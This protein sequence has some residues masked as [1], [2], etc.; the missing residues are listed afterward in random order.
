MAFNV[1]TFK[2]SNFGSDKGGTSKQSH[3]EL[4]VLPPSGILLSDKAFAGIN[5]FRFRT[6]SAEIPGRSIT[7]SEYK[8]AG[9]GLTQKMGYGVV[10]P[11]V[12]VTMVC[13]RDLA[14]KRLFTAWQS[15]IIGNHS[16]QQNIRRHQSIGYYNDYISTVA[17]LQY[18]EEG[19]PSY[20][21]A[22]Q[23]A[24]PI[25]VNSMP[26]N[27]GSEELHKLTIQFTYKYF[28]ETDEEARGQGARIG[29]AERG[30][31]ITGIS[32][33]DIAG[34]VANKLGFPGVGDFLQ[35]TG[36]PALGEITGNPIFNTNSF[37]LGGFRFP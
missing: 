11:D 1:N 32:L 23:E 4:L 28:T 18:D 13:N 24:Y 15:M 9:F 7:T 31:S 6:E 14:E 36:F 35:N 2:A 30:I 17:I 5:T 12:S 10:Y 29:G 26:L 33:G 21:M 20:A 25:I 22:L 37:T 27:W 34:G 19:N 16:R 3:F 8:S